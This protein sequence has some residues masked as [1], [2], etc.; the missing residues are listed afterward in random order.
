VNYRDVQRDNVLGDG[1]ATYSDLPRRGNSSKY[2]ARLRRAANSGED[3]SVNRVASG[4]VNSPVIR[5]QLFPAL[6][7]CTVSRYPHTRAHES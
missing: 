3:T 5:L 7:S 1:Q 4:T 2:V 6:R